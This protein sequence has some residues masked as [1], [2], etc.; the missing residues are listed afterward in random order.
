MQSIIISN[1][2]IKSNYYKLQVL[3]PAPL[4]NI[5]PGQF[6]ML[7]VNNTYDPLLRRPFSYYKISKPDNNPANPTQPHN[8][9]SSIIEFLY[10]VVGKGTQLMTQLQPDIE[11]DLLGPLGNGFKIE[12]TTKNFYL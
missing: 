11:I 9:P 2:N 3:Y 4:D 5:L 6:F 10:K 12:P 7:Q 8:Q 1:K